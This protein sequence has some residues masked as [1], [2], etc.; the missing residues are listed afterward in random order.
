MAANLLLLD[1]LFFSDDS[2]AE[3]A[4]N[5]EC[6]CFLPSLLREEHT[7]VENYLEEVVPR[8][9][10]AQFRRTL[11]VSRRVF[12]YLLDTLQL[13]TADGHHGGREPVSDRKKLAVF[14]RY[15]GSKSTLFELAQQFN[16][17]EYSV[18]RAR[19]EV[20]E[21]LLR[22]LPT[23]ITWPQPQEFAEISR[24]V[25]EFGQYTFPGI[26]GFLDGS[27]IPIWKP[28]VPN[29]DAY[30]NRK[31][32][33]SVN[34]Q[35]VCREDLRFT[36]VSVGCPGRMH[37]ARALRMSS[38]W[39][40]GYALCGQGAYHVLADA[41]YPLTSWMLT[42]YRNTGHLTPAEQHFKTAHSSKRQ[43]IERAF[44]VLKKRFPLLRRCIEMVSVE[45]IKCLP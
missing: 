44:G 22:L 1:E 28:R 41:A 39:N 15:V 38:L 26:V 37:D 8:F 7:K 36:D 3:Y 40:A 18:I 20:T 27:H 21:A 32:Y 45:N 43:T 11:R 24:E 2:D 35:A 14:L 33:H 25:S 16:I 6:E 29:P 19:Q 9:S 34:M 31:K 4:Y 13:Y 10:H 17:T 30:F 5:M 12:D 23:V 42:P